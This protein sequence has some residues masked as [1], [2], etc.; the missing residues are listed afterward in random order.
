LTELL[1][2]RDYYAKQIKDLPP[3]LA[4]EANAQMRKLDETINSLESLLAQEYEYY[5]AEKEREAELDVAIN[6]AWESSKHI[7]IFIKHKSPQMLEKFTNQVLAELPADLLEEFYDEVAV[8]E[9]TKL[10]E[11]LTGKVSFKSE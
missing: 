6:E 9:A 2:A 10:N 5:K 8:L 3:H 1:E 4:A 7:Y 11:I